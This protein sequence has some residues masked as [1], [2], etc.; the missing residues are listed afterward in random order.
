MRVL[1]VISR[2]NVGGTASWIDQ[3]ATSLQDDGHEVRIITGVTDKNEAQANMNPKLD[4][5]FLSNLKKKLS[6]GNDLRS[7][8]QIRKEIQL[9][10]PTIVNT[11][12]SKAG[13]L[14]RLANVTLLRQ[15]PKLVHTLHGHLLY[16]YF[17][18]WKIR[19][20][21]GVERFLGLFTDL[22]LVPGKRVAIE[23]ELAGLV[24]HIKVAEVVPGVV[25]QNTQKLSKE[26]KKLRVGWLGRL[27]QI[28]RPDRVI[29]LANMFPDV[30]F[31][32]GGDGELMS[33]LRAEAP[34]NVYLE[35]WVEANEFWSRVDIAL[36]TSDN[37]AMPI[38][39]I[40]A[41]MLGL[42]AVTT[43]VGSTSEVVIDG[44]SGFVAETDI[45]NLAD[46][47]RKLIESPELWSM[48]GEYARTFT[49]SNFSP[50][51]QLETHL[52][53]YEIAMGLKR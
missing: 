38:S 18:R 11:H 19:L 9:F 27:T 37:E 28:K 15:R 49:T 36:L 22:V 51:N 52:R 23:A 34:S 26:S 48:F 5:K 32:L 16:G 25:I 7:L 20:I 2:L 53:A 45:S 17:P 6:L 47:L 30:D 8:L 41:G 50:K 13:L 4:I 21:I 1:H 10:H 24:N 12:T 42:P 35:G 29:Q 14:T 46:A 43:N 3:L 40:E 39:L 31:L 44:K 33:V